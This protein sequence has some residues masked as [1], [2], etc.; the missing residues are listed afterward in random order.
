MAQ[1]VI[2]ITAYTS[3]GFSVYLAEIHTF[4]LCIVGVFTGGVI[5]NI[6]ALFMYEFAVFYTCFIEN[7]F[8]KLLF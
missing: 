5:L 7:Q 4:S 2:R 6:I 1:C 3:F 8:I